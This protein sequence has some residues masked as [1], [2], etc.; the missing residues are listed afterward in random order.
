MKILLAI[1]DMN[2]S[3]GGAERVLALVASGLAKMGH[4][5]TLLTYDKLGG[6]SYYPLDSKVSRI[7]LGIGNSKESASVNETTAR[8][9]AMRRVLQVRQ[10]D[11]V[12]PFM[13][14]MFIPMALAS[15]GLHIPVLA[16][17]HIVP[18]HYKTRP[19]QFILLLMSTFFIKKIT[20]L[21]PNVRRSY[22]K[23]VRR[24]MVVMPNPVEPPMEEYRDRKPERR[25][26]LNVGRLDE[27]KDQKTLIRAFAKIAD[28]YES[29]DVKIFGEGPLKPF[30]QSLIKKFNLENRVFL[31][32]TTPNIGSEY[33]QADIFAMPSKYESFG[34]A[35]AEAMSYGVP[36]IGFKECPGTNELIIHN[37]N[38]LL[39]SKNKK[40]RIGV[41]EGALVKLMKDQTK[42]ESL[43]EGA[44]SRITKFHPD[45]IIKQWV[46]LIEKY[47]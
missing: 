9:K 12:I 11:I 31:M 14:S 17:E 16:S 46:H 32:G 20:V 35:T 7:S 2:N 19:L 18:A 8:I 29:W 23:I 41:L 34:L 47:A 26:I 3:K 5:V 4:D 43:G 22:P 10:P 6:E 25:V 42:R 1:K 44:K 24:K 38:G 28:E 39:V 37:R 13:H 33:A 21:S 36:V 40:D 30:L 27:Q 15:I 45:I